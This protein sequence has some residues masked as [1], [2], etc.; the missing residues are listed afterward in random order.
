MGSRAEL[1]KR[2]KGARSNLLLM[3]GLSLLNIVLLILNAGISFLFSATAPTV[4]VGLGLVF[5]EDPTLNALGGICF[6]LGFVVIGIYG[7]FYWLSKK[8][9]AFMLVSFIFFAIDTLLLFW[10]LT[11]GFEIGVLIDIAFHVWVLYALGRGV[12]AWTHLMDLPDEP[13]AVPAAP[14]PVY[15]DVGPG[16]PPAP[17]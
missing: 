11:L 4:L 16:E 7:L 17:F 5:K 15:G 10:V 12:W 8:H 1:E 14:S 9:K 6:A 2:Y 13:P 3:I